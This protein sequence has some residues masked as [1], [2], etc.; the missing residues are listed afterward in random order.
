MP[1]LKILHVNFTNYIKARRKRLLNS[2]IFLGAG[3]NVN[4]MFK[5]LSQINP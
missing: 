1:F 4:W 3:V 5:F 2:S